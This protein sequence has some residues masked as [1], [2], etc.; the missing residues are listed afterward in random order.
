MAT[1]SGKDGKVRIGSAEVAEIT[2]WTFR[3]AAAN[4]SYA[5]SATGGF[6]RRVGGVREGSGTIAFKLDP[7]DPIT[8]HLNEG[9]SVTL[10]LHLDAARYYSVP[11]V[12]DALELE[13]DIDRGEIVGGRAE[14][15][16]DGAWTPPAYAS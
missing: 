4:A 10:L 11:A 15:S 3:T 13:V 16:T 7:A 9:Q 2:R 12:I 1:F 6:R 14:F 5:S 8:D